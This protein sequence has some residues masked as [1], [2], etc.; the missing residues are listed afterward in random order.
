MWGP[1]HGLNCHPTDFRA[2]GSPARTPPP[3]L[4]GGC[5]RERTGDGSRTRHTPRARL[6]RAGGAKAAGRGQAV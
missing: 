4:R 5:A 2:L 1:S 3:P 6:P